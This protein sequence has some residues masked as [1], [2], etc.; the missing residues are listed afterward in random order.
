MRTTVSNSFINS[1]NTSSFRFKFI[2]KTRRSNSFYELKTKRN[3]ESLSLNLSLSVSLSTSFALSLQLLVELLCLTVVDCE[4]EDN[5]WNVTM[6]ITNIIQFLDQQRIY[7]LDV[8]LIFLFCFCLNNLRQSSKLFWNI[9][10]AAPITLNHISSMRTSLRLFCLCLSSEI[11]YL[12]IFFLF[13]Q[14][15]HIKL[16]P[17]LVVS[18]L[19]RGI[20]Y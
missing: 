7:D 3:H 2:N 10:S 20:N 14:T 17:I 15:Q 8:S 11:F 19:F 9:V 16:L 12:F 13:G 1:F 6:S 4:R 5:F 18:W